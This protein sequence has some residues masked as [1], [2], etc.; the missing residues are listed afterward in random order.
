MD[1]DSST[2]EENPAGHTVAFATDRAPCEKIQQ[3]RSGIVRCS[4]LAGISFDPVDEPLV[5]ST[6]STSILDKRFENGLEV[7]DRTADDLEYLGRGGLLLQGL[8][9]IAVALLHLLKQTRVLNG[10]DGLVGEGLQQL[11]LPI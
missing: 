7:K 1:M 10:D 5:C 8:S 9:E 3:F 4:P 11:N 2:L 6:K